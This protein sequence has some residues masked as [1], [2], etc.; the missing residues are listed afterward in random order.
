MATAP[1]SRTVRFAAF[2][3][4]LRSRELR[5]HG[6]RI[7]LQEQ[8]FR[9]LELFLDRPGEL[10]TREEFQ[11]RIWPADT[12]VD[13]ELGLNTAV[14]RLRQALG[15]SADTPRFIETLPRRGYRF[16]FPVTLDSPTSDDRAG[17]NA[18][19]NAQP[20]IECADPASV[21]E[22]ARVRRTRTKWIATGLALVLAASGSAAVYLARRQTIRPD[23]QIHSIAVLPLENLSADPEQEFFADGMT[24]ELITE[25]A[26]LGIVRVISRSSVLRYKHSRKSLPDIA[27]ELHVDAVVEGTVLRSGDRVRITAQLIRAAD[28]RHLW[29]DRFER[30]LRDVLSLQA[31]LARAVA[32]NIEV[33]LTPPPVRL[34]ASRQVNPDA[35]DDYLRGRHLFHELSTPDGLD[36]AV[37]YYN[38]AIEKDPNF[39]PAYAGLAQCYTTGM[40]TARPLEPR[41]AWVRAAQTAEKALHLDDSLGQAHIAMA[42]VRFRYDWNWAEAEREFQR[43]IELNPND[44]DAYTS[45]S[46]FLGVMRRT[47]EALA[48]VRKAEQLDPLSPIISN[49]AAWNYS[50]AHRYDDALQQ[51]RGTLALDPN[52]AAAHEEMARSYEAKGMWKEAASEWTQAFTLSGMDAATARTYQQAYETGGMKALWRKW[53]ASDEETL[54][55]GGR[56][57]YME[58]ARLAFL[59]GDKDASF[60]WLEEAYKERDP[61]LPNLYFAANW[62]DDLRSDR[63]YLDLARRIG[64]PQ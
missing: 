20:P 19:V 46:V 28:D 13:F 34:S 59:V 49:V 38:L 32:I 22:L 21:T 15:D 51:E 44:A 26:K 45:Y 31:D 52:F 30:E 62:F 36:S 10:I 2:E 53:L 35:F 27:R 58:L 29:A 11:R 37:R 18:V 57:R 3:V 61:G 9:V 41:R 63:R 17:T 16:I 39:A 50:W 4:N 54:R 56:P 60:S 25:L 33:K 6:L 7:R 48:A 42:T 43:G 23:M 14:K 64:L 24:D 47:E 12:F 8:P 5:K 55:H 40:F 1:L